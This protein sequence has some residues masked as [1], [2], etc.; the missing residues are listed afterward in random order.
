M[1]EA[2]AIV[3]CLACL[4]LCVNARVDM[5][6]SHKTMHIMVGFT[7]SVKSKKL[8]RLLKNILKMVE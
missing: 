5:S 1:T 8:L 2:A 3:I 6:A 7:I 4:G